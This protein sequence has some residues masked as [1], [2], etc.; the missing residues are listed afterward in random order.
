MS[1]TV[2]GGYLVGS[3]WQILRF[4][5]TVNKLNNMSYVGMYHVLALSGSSTVNISEIYTARKQIYLFYSVSYHICDAN[6]ITISGI[7][8]AS[9]PLCCIHRTL[10]QIPTLSSPL[11]CTHR[12]LDLH[13]DIFVHASNAGQ[14][15]RSWILP[16]CSL[17]V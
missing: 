12:T 6:A 8:Q 1:T 5:F 14:T 13:S 17:F 11:C 10:D 7:E 4:D 3:E 9:N 15:I 2:Q 16:Q